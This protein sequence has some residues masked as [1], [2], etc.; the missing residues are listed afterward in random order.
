MTVRKDKLYCAKL[1]VKV[2]CVHCVV[3]FETVRNV[4]LLGGG[5]EMEIFVS[6]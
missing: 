5:T 3:Q 4:S 6:N 1:S 2:H